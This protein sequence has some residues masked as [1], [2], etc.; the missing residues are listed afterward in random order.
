MSQTGLTP[1][2]ADERNRIH[3]IFRDLCFS[4]RFGVGGNNML[5]RNESDDCVCGWVWVKGDGQA[6]RAMKHYEGCK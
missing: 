5:I 3:H 1:P 6:Q 2:E 4:L